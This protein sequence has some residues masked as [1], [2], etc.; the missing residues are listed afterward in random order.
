MKRVPPRENLNYRIAS[1][2]AECICPMC[3]IIHTRRVE[4]A[5]TDSP[6]AWR[7]VGYPVI[8]CDHCRKENSNDR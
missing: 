6:Y 5:H 7:R 3:N 1:P 4:L 2:P 8:L